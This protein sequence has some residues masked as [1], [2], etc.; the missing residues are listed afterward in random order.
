MEAKSELMSFK[1]SPE[2]KEKAERAAKRQGRS[3]SSY[4]RRVL[5]LALKAEGELEQEDEPAKVPA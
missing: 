4:M 3:L 5:R 1:A 2:L